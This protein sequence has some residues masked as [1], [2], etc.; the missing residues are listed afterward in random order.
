MDSKTSEDK[1]SRR[2]MAAEARKVN[3]RF[4]F[5]HVNYVTVL[6]FLS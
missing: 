5:M 1:E 3:T 4:N 6:K 2:R